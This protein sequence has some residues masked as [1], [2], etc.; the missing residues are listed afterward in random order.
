[1]RK[2]Q[3][4]GN[5][6]DAIG[7]LRAQL[8]AALEHHLFTGRAARPPVAGVVLWEAF[9]ALCAGRVYGD[10]GPGPISMGEVEAYTRLMRVELPPHHVQILRAMDAA[11]LKW[12]RTPEKDRPAGEMT[13]AAFDAVFG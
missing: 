8:V 13:G 4:V 2:R 12:A 1:M 11:W 6:G 3:T 10:V 9:A 5:R 7:R